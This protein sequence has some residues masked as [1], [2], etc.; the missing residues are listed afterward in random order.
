MTAFLLVSLLALFHGLVLIFAPARYITSSRLGESTLRLVKKPPFEFGKL[1]LGLVVSGLI[2]GV[3]VRPVV[4]WMLHPTARVISGGKSPLPEG[5]A[6]WD[7]LGIAVFA[8][9]AGYILLSR[10]EKSVELLFTADK[11]KLEDKH[12]LRLWTIYVQL[13]GIFCVGWSLLPAAD[14]FRSL[15]S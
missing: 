13:F 11:Q 12:T 6:R 10:A 9:V 2:V 3:F 5:T 14:F 8:V 1:F 7:L 15:H 4:S